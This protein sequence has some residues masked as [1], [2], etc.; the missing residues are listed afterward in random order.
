MPLKIAAS[1]TLMATAQKMLNVLGLTSIPQLFLFINFT[2]QYTAYIPNQLVYKTKI[3]S[4][5]Y[6]TKKLK[7]VGAP[8][9]EVGCWRSQILSL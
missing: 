9:L 7:I 2:L 6:L 4:S 5:P 3:I 1:F 8:N